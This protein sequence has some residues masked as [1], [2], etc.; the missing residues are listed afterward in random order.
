M[1]TM[2]EVDEDDQI[3][4]ESQAGVPVIVGSTTTNDY[5]GPTVTTEFSGFK[6]G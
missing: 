5:S 3:T 6:L 4:V 2:L 1:S